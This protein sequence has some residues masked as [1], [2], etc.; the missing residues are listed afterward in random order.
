M[1]R[2]ALPRSSEGSDVTSL[3]SVLADASRV[4]MLDTLLDGEAYSIGALARRAGV[5]ASTASSHLRRLSA[6]RLVA[7]AQ[8]GRERRVRLAGPD[9]AEL[10]ERLAVL[11]APRPA[12]TPSPTSQLRFARTCYDHLAGMLG[13]AVSAAL[14]ER[15]WLHA[16]TDTF[17]PAPAL[18]AWLAQLGRPVAITGS[19]RPLTRAC[20]DWSERVPHVAGRIGA[21]IAEVFV[22]H[23]WVARI[24]GT[25]ALRLTAGGRSAVVREL[26]V[27]F[28][29]RVAR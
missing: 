12:S 4:A 26:G 20:L 18:F 21:A 11:A 25:R 24:R 17:E 7:V 6:A 5:S 1:P 22:D 27:A 8:V 10:L 29:G 13:V 14:V 15:G 2:R 16:T 23:G 28:P 3:A 9:V 19:R